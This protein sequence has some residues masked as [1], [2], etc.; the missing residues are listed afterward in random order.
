M[1][2]RITPTPIRQTWPEKRSDNPNDIG[3]WKNISY[4][5]D[6]NLERLRSLENRAF[7]R[8]SRVFFQPRSMSRNT[9]FR[10]CEKPDGQS[11]RLLRII[12]ENARASASRRSG[13][14]FAMTSGQR[15]LTCDRSISSQPRK[16]MNSRLGGVLI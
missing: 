8:I 14:A 16:H 9:L 11:S 15:D 7:F 4:R 2:K 3:S 10:K 5:L 12:T 13:D 1:E 6:H